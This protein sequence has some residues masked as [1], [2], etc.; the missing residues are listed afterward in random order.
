M[1]RMV[2]VTDLVKDNLVLNKGAEIGVWKGET[3]EYLLKH[4]PELHLYCIDPYQVY[5]HYRKHHHLGHYEDPALLNELAEA[6]RGRLERKFPNRLTWL[7][8]K[9]V[10][11]AERVPAES[12]DFVFIDGNH[13]HEYVLQDIEVW[14]PKVRSGGFV[15]GHDYYS[16]KDSKECVKRAVVKMFGDDHK[17]IDFC[18]YHVK[19]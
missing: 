6:V 11:A 14:T 8:M 7:Q 5:E 13:G 3:S 18:W 19:P 2:I 17:V 15:T 9:S 10:E 12:L 4:L 1:N 16:N